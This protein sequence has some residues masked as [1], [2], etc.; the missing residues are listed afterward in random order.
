MT[1]SAER[2]LSPTEA[3]ALVGRHPDTIIRWI[4]EGRLRNAIRL[5]SGR[6]RIDRAELE[7]LAVAR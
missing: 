4:R 3:G 2:F 5:P 1:I 6:V 7:K